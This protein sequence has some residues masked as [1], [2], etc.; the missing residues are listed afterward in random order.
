MASHVLYFTILL[1]SKLNLDNAIIPIK[2]VLNK[3]TNHC[4]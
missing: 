2:S 4:Y 3:D 1:K